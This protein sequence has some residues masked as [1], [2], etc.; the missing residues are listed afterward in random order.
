[1]KKKFLA[2]A[3]A[4]AVMAPTTSAF[5]ADITHTVEGNATETLG[6][7]VTISG[8]IKNGNGIAPAGKIEVEMPTKATFAVDQEGNFKGSGFTVTNRSSVPVE[9]SVASF[10]ESIPSGGITIDKT[11]TDKTDGN[12]KKPEEKNISEVGRNTVRLYLDATSGGKRNGFDLDK[13]VTNQK[14][15]DIAKGDT[16]KVQ[17]LGIAGTKT[18]GES[19]NLKNNGESEDFTISFK[20]KKADDTAMRG[21]SAL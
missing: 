21:S 4:L 11:I 8:S 5:A 10:S 14:L 13:L 19:E 9:L 1:M 7:D 6:A 12:G 18:E 20:I 17:V 16:A 3:L 15:V 2:L